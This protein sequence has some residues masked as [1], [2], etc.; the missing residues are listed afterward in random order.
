MTSCGHLITGFVLDGCK[1]DSFVL[2]VVTSE[3]RALNG[4]SL[5]PEIFSLSLLCACAKSEWFIAGR[6]K[7]EENR[8]KCVEKNVGTRTHIYIESLIRNEILFVHM[9]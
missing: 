1:L 8:W 7:A 4:S 3:Q 9:R 6:V 5:E 2:V